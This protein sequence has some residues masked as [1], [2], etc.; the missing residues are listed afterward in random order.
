MNRKMTIALILPFLASTGMVSQAEIIA[1]SGDHY[2]LKHQ[3]ESSLSPDEIW[4][5]LG[6]PASWWHP[7]HT[8]SGSSDNLTITL[9]AGGLWRE[10]WEGGSV[11]HG[12]VVYFQEG[13][14]L[15]LN[16]PFGPL[17]ALGV[18]TIWTIT[19]E[20]TE[21]GT[22][23][24]FDEVSNGSAASN[25]DEMAQAVDYVKAEAITRLAAITPGQPD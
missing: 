20:P 7:D 5:R 24:T 14:Q 18:T 23:I 2:T 13:K 3:A 9:E 6:D 12:E 22:L 17:Q 15:R 16:A 4:T 21:T 8:Y 1:A 10:D 25:L 19:L 11:A